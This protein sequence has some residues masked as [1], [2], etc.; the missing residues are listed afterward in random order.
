MTTAI[1]PK[2]IDLTHSEFKLDKLS[3]CYDEPNDEYVKKT[4]GLLLDDKYTKSVSGLTITKSPRYAVS[5][6][7]KLPYSEPCHS[8]QIVTF[9]AGPYLPGVASYRWEGNPDKISIAGWDDL[10]TLLSSCIDVDPIAFFRMSKITRL[11]VALDLPGLTLEEVIVRSSR[12]QKHGVYSNRHGDPEM[13]YLGTPRSRRIA[14]YDKPVEGSMKTALRVETRLKP[15]C[16]GYEVAGLKNPFAN[17][18][19]IPS[20]FSQL[21]GLSIP[22][23]C[24]AD[25]VRMGGLKRALLPLNTAQRKA[26]KNAYAKAVSVLPSTDALWANWPQTLAGY[27]LGQHLGATSNWTSEI[28]SKAINCAVS[29]HF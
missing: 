6:R 8:P 18:Q 13:T 7:I 3:V 22:S 2:H 5:C 14:S 9:Q 1:V 15:G 20:S 19:L 29:G 16:L 23:Q 25:S 11:D 27:G 26:L 4:C 24:I 21:A 28:G 12:L 10:Y 17:V